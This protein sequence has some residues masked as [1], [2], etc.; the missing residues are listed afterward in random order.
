[1]S[2]HGSAS[3]LLV[4][5][6]TPSARRATSE[7][8]AADPA[9]P[10][11]IHALCEEGD[12]PWPR[13]CGW[14]FPISIHALCEEG[15]QGRL[16]ELPHIRQFLSTPSARRATAFPGGLVIHSLFLSTPSARRATQIRAHNVHQ[17]I[18]SIHAL[19]EEGDAPS[20]DTL[21]AAMLF[22]STPS[23]RRATLLGGKLFWMVS[24][25]YPRPLRGGRRE[26]GAARRA[27]G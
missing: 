11:S 3:Q 15:D 9:A 23:A 5:L 24:Y 18:I 13:P 14:R 12:Q 1:M 22:L 8:P 2:S 21:Q 10:I 16:R 25:F 4:F 7:E 26:R 6:S 27:G 19:C 17:I 20:I